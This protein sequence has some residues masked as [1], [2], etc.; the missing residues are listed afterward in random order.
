[1]DDYN[2]LFFDAIIRHQIGLLRVSGKV[3]NRILLLLD[4]TER[5]IRDQ[6]LRKLQ[7][8]TV[9]TQRLESLIASIKAIRSDAWKASA[10]AWQE[11]LL[12]LA[13]EEPDFMAKMLRT[14]APVQLDLVLPSAELLREIVR[15]RPFEGRVLKDWAKDISA[16]DL[17]RIEQQIR[18]G[19][20]QGESAS[21]IARRIVG[22][23]QRRG[24]DG[25]LEITRRQAAAITRTAVIGISNQ[26]K[27]EFYK[28]N[29]T[30]FAEEIYVATLDSR[31]TP[32][33][34]ALDGTRHPVG[35]GP[36]PP[37]HFNCRSVR[38]A[39]LDGT[40]LGS[41]PV[42]N[43]T[44]QRLLREYNAAHGTSATTRAGLPRGHKGQFDQ[45]VR[46]R[47]RQLTGTVDAN[48]TYQKWLARQTAQFQDD[49]LGPTRGKLF[50]K[51]GLT[52]DK[53]VNRR[54]DE[55]TLKELAEKERKAFLAA[56]LDPDDFT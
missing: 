29:S 44:Q 17:G 53:F 12:A 27:R 4:A 20:T 19:V 54:G 55:L 34:R 23:V 37:L 47:I 25:V 46:E 9:S 30:L 52:L 1:M 13:K 49:I 36:I 39:T 5:D 26:A 16:A 43:Y 28:A 38:V 31:T 42:R 24:T 51:G 7:S 32:V 14:I 11:E 21:A 33:C 50:R 41:R 2:D 6:I 45:F 18:I 15:A 40:A 35:E 10:E 22:T 56:G 8:G 48:V 3:R